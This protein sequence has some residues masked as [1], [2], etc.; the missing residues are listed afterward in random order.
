MKIKP[1]VNTDS[2]KCTLKELFIRSVLLWFGVRFAAKRILPTTTEISVMS[3]LLIKVCKQGFTFKPCSSL[4]TSS[5]NTKLLVVHVLLS[6]VALLFW[7][8]FHG[9]EHYRRFDPVACDLCSVVWNWHVLALASVELWVASAV[10]V[11]FLQPATTLLTTFSRF[12]AKLKPSLLQPSLALLFFLT[13]KS[14]LFV[15]ATSEDGFVVCT[16][17]ILAFTRSFHS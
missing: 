7:F 3:N 9:G 1:R 12:T 5:L 13:G 4:L 6:L 17:E 10:P 2:I 8:H 14:L 15:H 11:F 16:L